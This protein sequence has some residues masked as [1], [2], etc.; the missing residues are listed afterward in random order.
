MIARFGFV[1]ASMAGL[2]ALSP[3]NAN[4]LN[5][6][7]Q[8]GDGVSLIRSISAP[9]DSCPM[10]KVDAT[11]VTM[12]QRFAPDAGAFAAAP[13]PNYTAT[14][15]YPGGVQNLEFPIKMCEASVTLDF[16]AANA[17]ITDPITGTSTTLK[18]PI[19][20]PKRLLIIGDT[21]CRISNK[22]AAASDGTQPCDNNPVNNVSGFPTSYLS[23]Y[24]SVFKPDMIV[25]TGDFYYREFI[26]NNTDYCG[27]AAG[28][29]N[30]GENW[31][32]WN[33]DW[34]YPAAGLMKAAPLAL[35][36]GNHESCARGARGWFKLL[37]VHPYSQTGGTFDN[38]NAANPYNC[39]RAGY[40][41]YRQFT[42]NALLYPSGPV[43]PNPT[44]AQIDPLDVTPP[45]VVPA[46]PLSLIMFDESYASDSTSV[47][48]TNLQGLYQSQLSAALTKAAGTHSFL[49]LHKPVY[50]INNAG[51][52][53]VPQ[54]SVSVLGGNFNM[55]AALG[56]QVDTSISLIVSGH[57][58]NYQVVDL[59]G[60][61]YAP[62]LVIG[63]SGT[64][65]DGQQVCLKASLSGTASCGGATTPTSVVMG[66]P[67]YYNP[68]TGTTTGMTY[69]QDVNAF[70]FAVLD[71]MD[72]NTY[73]ANVYTLN[74]VKAGRCVIK[75]NPRS[76]TCTG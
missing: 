56:N 74:A 55:Q 3:A 24:A 6:W 37:D 8:Y 2:A 49:V 50:G 25:H 57:T 43:V 41:S 29:H 52:A 10:L 27:N 13:V 65:L 61:S 58:H 31:D 40:V 11:T 53:S 46:G 62:Q 7:V 19:A 67:T 75:L 63:N 76:M 64:L 71:Y 42:K 54:A 51:S 15:A 70:G 20:K 68:G 34:F 4:V 59:Q 38:P 18:M 35:T 69:V 22:G 12:T 48:S 1:L 72:D 36:R 5:T 32:S 17:T 28:G 14:T 47:N 23:Q 73:V 66:A 60:S 44:V 45:Y 16:A 30:W 21:G 39:P 33:G 9:G 26:C